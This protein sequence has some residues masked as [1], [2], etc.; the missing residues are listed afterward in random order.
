MLSPRTTALAIVSGALE[1]TVRPGAAGRF[2]GYID[3]KLAAEKKTKF[4]KKE[5]GYVGVFPPPFFWVYR[6]GQCRFWALGQCD[7]VEGDISQVGWCSIWTAPTKPER[8]FSWVRRIS[9]LP[10]FAGEAINNLFTDP[11]TTKGEN[12]SAS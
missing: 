8:P 11:F 7:K 1:G 10:T 5:V 9:T 3:R 6:C 2:E 12:E 4:T